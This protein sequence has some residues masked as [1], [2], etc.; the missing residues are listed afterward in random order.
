MKK[1][2]SILCVLTVLSLAPAWGQPRLSPPGMP[3]PSA[4]SQNND[5]TSFSLDFRGGTPA[6]LIKAIEKATGKPLNAII[7]SEDADTQLPSLKMNDVNVAQL[8]QALEKA[9]L[10]QVS[11]VSSTSYGFGGQSYSTTQTYYSFTT[12]ANPPT[13]NSIWYF[14]VSKPSLPLVGAPGPSVCQFYQLQPYIERGF[15][16]DDIT[17]AIQT[18]W[19]MAGVTSPPELNYHKQTKLLIAFGKP[20]DLATVNNVLKALPES[21]I[22]ST[23]LQ[24]MQ[25]QIDT[26][27]REVDFLDKKINTHSTHNL[28]LTNQESSGN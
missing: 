2:L 22:S 27:N 13:D 15:T 6:D 20:E 24:Q 3:Q 25:Q 19:K 5:L 28:G 7:P 8:F 12:E 4:P 14:Q 11:Y 18:G 23:K 16:V 1:T 9:S 10:K 17:T 21:N 26:L